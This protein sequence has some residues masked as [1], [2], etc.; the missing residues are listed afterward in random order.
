MIDITDGIVHVVLVAFSSVVLLISLLA[1]ADRKNSRY[2]FLCLAFASLAA[3][4]VVGLMEAWFFSTQ[5]VF[6]PSTGI[7]LSHFLEFLMLAS[8][9]LALLVK[10]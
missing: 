2:F 1:Y 7:H 10:N 6:I 4:E 9:S 8:F 5:L 3:S